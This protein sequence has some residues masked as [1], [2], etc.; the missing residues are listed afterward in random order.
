MSKIVTGGFDPDTETFEHA[1]Y[2]RRVPAVIYQARLGGAAIR[3]EREGYGDHITL[4]RRHGWIYD[5]VASTGG[6]V[7]ILGWSHSS[8][9]YVV[10]AYGPLDFTQGVRGRGVMVGEGAEIGDVIGEAGLHWIF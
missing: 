9:S 7:G 6:V 2:S 8:D 4:V 10:E 5:V 3:V 1:D